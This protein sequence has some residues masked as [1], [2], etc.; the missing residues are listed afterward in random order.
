MSREAGLRLDSRD[1]AILRLPSG[2]T[3]IV[4]GDPESSELV[5][6][7]FATDD[8]LLMPPPSSN[9][10]LSDRE[11]ELLADWIR[12]GA[13]FIRHWS[14]EPIGR[15]EP[16]AVRDESWVRNP[17]DRFVLARLEAEGLS[18]S[19]AA[20][21]VRLV[22]RV[23]LDLTGL[24][25]TPE[26][27]DRFARDAERPDAY[28]LLVDDLLASPAFGERMAWDW[29][30]LARYADSNGYQGDGER[31][32]WP[33]RDWV[34]DAFNRDVPYDRFTVMQLAGDLL[35]NASFE[36]VLATGFARNHMING[37]GGRIP[38]ENRVDYVMD[39]TETTGTV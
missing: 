16:P 20:E 13:P 15:P 19:P 37:E 12:A 21:P 3:A 11:R 17:I 26:L 29:L 4:P 27:A 35:P 38:E 7:I 23:S 1:D 5:R 36:D 24:P 33:W 22:R 31:T 6:R 2:E 8:D 25:P 30:D 32:M 28:D 10:G 34:I 39:M 18:P 9:R 14:L